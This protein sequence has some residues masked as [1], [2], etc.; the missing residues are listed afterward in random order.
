MQNEIKT[1]FIE[2]RKIKRSNISIITPTKMITN[3]LFLYLFIS[4]Y[5]I[6]G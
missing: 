5:L 1:I 4:F 6:I 2:R 3:N